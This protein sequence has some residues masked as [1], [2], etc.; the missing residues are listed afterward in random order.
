MIKVGDKILQKKPNID[1]NFKILKEYLNLN[2]LIVVNK[3][4]EPLND[5]AILSCL[6]SEDSH[7]HVKQVNVL[8]QETII[9]TLQFTSR[10]EQTI[11][12]TLDNHEE[13]AVFQTFIEIIEA[14]THL[15]KVAM[16]F[17]IE[18]INSTKIKELSKKGLQQMEQKNE[19]YILELIEYECLPMVTS[20]SE[21][22]EERK[23]H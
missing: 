10:V 7:F 6:S 17:S 18:D 21:T 5:Q 11:K 23:L 16:Y 3:E 2:K 20:F 19:S 15:E 13:V 8:E 14:L 1:D 4:G 22:L 12:D 9:E